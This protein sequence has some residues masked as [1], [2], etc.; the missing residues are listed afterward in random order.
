[1]VGK[2]MDTIS[3]N[4]KIDLIFQQHIVGTHW[5]NLIEA[6]IARQYQCVPTTYI[7]SMIDVFT[8]KITLFKLRQEMIKLSISAMTVLDCW[9][10]IML[11][12]SSKIGNIVVELQNVL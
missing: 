8:K 12:F 10:L 4:F 2:T 11:S 6:D 1:M 3:V 9:K 5:N 7:F